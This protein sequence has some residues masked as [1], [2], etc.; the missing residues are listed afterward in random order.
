MGKEFL[1][2]VADAR[3]FSDGEILIFTSKTALD[4][5]IAIST[6]S[7]NITGGQANPLLFVY[8]HSPEVKIELT[9]AQFNLGMIAANVGSEIITGADVWEEEQVTIGASGVGTVV[10]T[11]LVTPDGDTAIYGWVTVSDVTTKV[12]FTGKEFTYGSENDVVCVYYYLNDSSAKE[13]SIPSKVIPSIGRLVLDAQLGSQEGTASGSSIIGKVEIEIPRFLLSGNQDISM[14]SSGVSTTPLS[15]MALAYQNVGCAGAGDY[16]K[17]R[18]IITDASW[19][20]D[21]IA[22]AI[23]D[24]GALDLTHPDTATLSVLAIPNNGSAFKPPYADLDFTSSEVGFATV[25]AH[26][27]ILTT[28]A[29]GSTLISISVTGKTAVFAEAEVTVS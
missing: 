5:S 12:T 7:E 9:D 26:T 15:G 10:G 23:E 2:G 17:I 8:F 13:V 16:A 6:S 3:F 28:V 19:S 25:G 21:V 29:T 1:V 24:N 4:T 27:G 22:L 18:R 14:S 11:P 20:D